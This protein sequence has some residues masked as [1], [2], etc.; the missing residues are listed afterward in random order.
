MVGPNNAADITTSV[1]KVLELC[2]TTMSAT[3]AIPA[4]GTGETTIIQKQQMYQMNVKY[5]F[6]N[7]FP[8]ERW[9]WSKWLY[10]GYFGWSGKPFDSV[11]IIQSS[12][13]NRGGIWAEDFR[14]ILQLY[15]GE[16]EQG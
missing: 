12:E 5:S 14:C 3:V 4:I 8:R 11:N 15:E 6:K 10:Q 13:N 9:Y 2:E 1:E 16:E 7:C